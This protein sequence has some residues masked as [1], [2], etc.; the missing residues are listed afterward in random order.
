MSEISNNQFALE[1]T[2]SLLK[3]IVAKAL[4]KGASAAEVAVTK[5]CGLSVSTRN[6]DIE[7]LEFNQD[8]AFG[9]NLYLGKSKGSASTNDTSPESIEKALDAAYAI[10]KYTTEDPYSGLAD[11]ELMLKS[12]VDLDLYHPAELSPEQAK[13]VAI[14]AEAAGLAIPGIVNSEGANLNSHD[15]MKVY[16]NSHGFVE[17]FLSSRHSLSC[18]MIAQSEGGMERDY[19]YSVSRRYPELWTPEQIGVDAAKKAVGRL[20]ARQVKTGAYPVLFSADVASS[21]WGH[22]LAGLRGS[23]LYRRSSFLLDKLG[24]QI[25]PQ[26]VSLQERPHEPGWLGSA[27]FDNDGVATYEK[28]IVAAGRLESY[29]LDAYSAR[30]LKMKTTGNAGGVHNLVVSDSGEGLD[31]LVKQ[32][33]TGLL[34]TEMMGHGVNMVNGDY[35]RGAAGFWIENGEISYPVSGITIASNLATMFSD[36]VAIGNDI[37]VRKS[38][39][40]GSV[41]IKSMMVAGN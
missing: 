32:V 33:G 30:R 5:E 27:C 37:D 41:L 38:I 4:K 31:E 39:R 8:G 35:S 13:D 26:W 14:A 11:A 18:S 9:I 1:E 3:A 10:A 16:A 29:L 40:S 24:E 22:L 23:A 7:V 17:G 12:C 34:V 15:A 6:K 20:D 21:L 19:S 28:D 25:L 36:V 2:K